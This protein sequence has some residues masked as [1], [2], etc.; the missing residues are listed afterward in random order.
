MKTKSHWE[1]VYKNKAPDEV[2]WFRPHSEKSVQLIEDAVPDRRSAIIDVG[3][4]ESTLADDL[5]MLGYRDISVLDVSLVAIRAVQQRLGAEADTIKWLIG[6]LTQV[7]LPEHRYDVWHDRAVFHFLTEPNQ[8]ERY[9]Q[10]ALRSLRSNGHLIIGV[11]G[12]DGP[13]QCSSLKVERHDIKLLCDRLGPRFTLVGAST[14][15]HL[16]PGGQSQQ[17][18]YAHFR[19]GGG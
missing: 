18:L 12:P 16:T 17:F 15:D 8:R 3:G 5:L 13:Q 2:S 4:G 9:V 6:D 14:E 10:Q 19:L 11:F 7:D 1:A